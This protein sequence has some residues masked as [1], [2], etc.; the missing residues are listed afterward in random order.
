MV[1]EFMDSILPLMDREMS[2]PLSG[3]SKSR[4]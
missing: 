2:E 3:C 1:I 4:A